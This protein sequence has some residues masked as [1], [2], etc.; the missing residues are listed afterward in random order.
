M[1]SGWERTEHLEQRAEPGSGS[2]GSEG[3]AEGGDVAR[4]LAAL[5]LVRARLPAAAAALAA[6]L[7]HAPPAAHQ[8]LR[9]ILQVTTTSSAQH[10]STV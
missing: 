5:A 1:S 4:S 8:P 9:Q 10:P 3:V 2:D 7:P 6:A